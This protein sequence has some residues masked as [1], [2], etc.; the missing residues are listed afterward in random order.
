[1]EK[2]K[3]VVLTHPW[4]QRTV[5]S[6]AALASSL[7][8]GWK[9]VTEPKPPTTPAAERQK[10]YRQRRQQAGFRRLNVLL[11]VEAHEAILAVQRSGETLADT[12][13]RL[14]VTALHTG[15]L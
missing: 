1:M 6:E 13:E 2:M 11:P 4:H 12:L 10:L 5:D 7:A 8:G 15:H 3:P 14:A 9:I